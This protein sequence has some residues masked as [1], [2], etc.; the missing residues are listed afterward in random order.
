MKITKRQLRKIIAESLEA[1]SSNESVYEKFNEKSDKD[2]FDMWKSLESN[3]KQFGF[4][5]ASFMMDG[6]EFIAV[7]IDANWEWGVSGRDRPH[8]SLSVIGKLYMK[9]QD[10]EKDIWSFMPFGPKYGSWNVGEHNFL[11]IK[12][13]QLFLSEIQKAM[14]KLPDPVSELE[15]YQVTIDEALQMIK[16]KQIPEEYYEEALYNAEQAM[17][18]GD[19]RR[20]G[21]WAP[22]LW[23]DVN[24]YTISEGRVST[25]ITK[26]Q[27]RRIIREEYI[28][29][30][31]RGL[32][33]EVAQGNELEAAV[34]RYS[35]PDGRMIWQRMAK[36]MFYD[37]A[38]GRDGDGARDQYYPGWEDSDFVYVIEQIDGEYIEPESGG[39]W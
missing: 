30:K 8:K 2:R 31:K 34:N 12:D 33:K 25:K 37:M 28:R 38:A 1:S 10:V 11:V 35:T 29:L 13:E 16:D 32:I 39:W 9:P 23:H 6:N 26:R 14:S 20:L 22:T 17:E 27:L 18:K 19:V 21:Y 15:K 3:S 5:G 36:Q 24:D 4:R 7:Q